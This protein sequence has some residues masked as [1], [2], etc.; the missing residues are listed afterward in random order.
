MS[1]LYVF[2]IIGRLIFRNFF[3]I[4][5]LGGGGTNNYSFTFNDFQNK[6]IKK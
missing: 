2:N 3:R 5:G 6:K 4:V 1:L